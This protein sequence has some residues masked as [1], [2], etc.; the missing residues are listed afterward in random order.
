[1]YLFQS[2]DTSSVVCPF[3]ERP[4]PFMYDGT[5]C[6]ALCSAATGEEKHGYLVP[7]RLGTCD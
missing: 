2:I 5:A 7:D 6:C 3:S 4:D 1:M